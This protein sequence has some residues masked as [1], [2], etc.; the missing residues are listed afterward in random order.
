V[1]G[2]IPK[3]LRRSGI[4]YRQLD[5]WVRCGY[6]RPE[7]AEP[8]SGRARRWPEEEIEIARTMRRLVDVGLTNAVA[9]DVARTYVAERDVIDSRSPE[10]RLGV[11]IRIRIWE[12]AP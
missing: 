7:V 5:Y 12:V 6:L 9:A 10:I 8:G 1:K 2:D 3:V 11:G 4:S